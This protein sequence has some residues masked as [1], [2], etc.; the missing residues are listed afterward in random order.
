MGLGRTIRFASAAVGI[1]A[2]AVFVLPSAAAYGATINVSPGQSIQAAV[3]AAHAGDTI[4][5]AAG[6]YHESVEVTKSLNIIGAGQGATILV[7]PSTPPRSQSG[8]CFDPSAPTEFDGMCI[9]GAVDSKG[10]VTSPVGA[11]R[12]SGFTVK[13]FNGIGV[14]FFGASSPHVDH[15]TFLNNSDYGTTAFVSTNDFFDS[16]ISN[17]NGEAGIYVG[18]SPHANATVTNNQAN[19]NEN[20]GIFVRDAS[21]PGMIANNVVRGNCGGILFLNTGSNPSNWQASG[22][23]ASANDAVCSP[24]GGPTAGG[25]GIGVAGVNSVNVHD[26]LVTNNV[27]SGPVQLTGGVLV[28]MGA[29]HTTVTKNQITRNAPDIFWDKSG[30]A[31]SFSGNLCKTSV[32]SGLC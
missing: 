20:F 27:P 9:H 25:I 23:Q 1:A 12:V 7:P 10:N 32:P 24:E 15:N 16:N 4:N 26:N 31:N 2:M 19:N 17:K 18:D 30:T 29:S 11:V 3:N 6:T 5:V 22:N 14:V 21:G 8:F 28:G 13:N